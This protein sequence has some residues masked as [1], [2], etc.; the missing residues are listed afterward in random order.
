MSRITSVDLKRYKC[1]TCNEGH[2]HIP[3][4]IILEFERLE[5]AFNYQTEQYHKLEKSNKVYDAMIK[6]LKETYLQNKDERFWDSL[7]FYAEGDV[8]A[9]EERF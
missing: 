2:Y 1:P 5:R 8:E 4:E 6:R 7:K 9:E 3:Q